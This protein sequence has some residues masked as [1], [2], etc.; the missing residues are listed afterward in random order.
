MVQHVAGA[1]HGT[2]V[3]F[4]HSLHTGRRTVLLADQR[5]ITMAGGGWSSNHR[6]RNLSMPRGRHARE[7][8][9]RSLARGLELV[10]QAQS[11]RASGERRAGLGTVLR[12]QRPRLPSTMPSP[13]GL[14]GATGPLIAEL[15][16]EDKKARRLSIPPPQASHSTAF[17]HVSQKQSTTSTRMQNLVV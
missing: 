14:R 7:L 16:G 2:Q 11:C 10:S 9:P 15:R 1:A 13:C 5:E 12:P 17:P 6:C 4:S 8:Q 3:C